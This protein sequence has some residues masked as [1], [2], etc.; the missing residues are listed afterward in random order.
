[1]NRRHFIGSVAAAGLLR[2]SAADVKVEI[3]RPRSPYEAL[4]RDIEPGH[5]DFPLEKEAFEIAARLKQL[6]LTPDFRGSSPLPVRYAPVA[7]GVSR[8]KFDFADAAFD[9]GLKKWLAS[10]GEIRAIRFFV[11]AGDVVRYEIAAGGQ[12]HVGLWKQTWNGGLLAHFA[13]IE[14]TLTSASGPLF[15][16]ITASTFR[17]VRSFDDQLSHGIPYSRARLDSAA[18]STSTAI[19][20]SRSEISTMTAPTRSTFP[21]G[22][23]PESA[24]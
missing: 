15:R 24:L 8:A 5:D 17:G 20:A 2:A 3:V 16:D 7:E 19:T 11:L 12:Y 22:R 14:E 6:T 13:P 9:A 10:L 18:E 23:P 1:M 21:A 4:L